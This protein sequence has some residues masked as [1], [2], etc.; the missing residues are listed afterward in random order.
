MNCPLGL[1][2]DQ[3]KEDKA[4]VIRDREGS[5]ERGE[6]REEE[7]RQKTGGKREDRNY[8]M[9]LYKYSRQYSGL[10]TM[11]Q[12]LIYSIAVVTIS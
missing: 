1:I 2:F 6:E 5:F 10:A 8:R 9:L 7:R 3:S 11:S 4:E 12:A